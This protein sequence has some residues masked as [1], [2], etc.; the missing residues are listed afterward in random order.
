M[1][2]HINRVATDEAGDGEGQPPQ[3]AEQRTAQKESRETKPDGSGMALE[4]RFH[5]NLHDQ[6]LQHYPRPR[7]RPRLPSLAG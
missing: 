1:T 7:Y 6:R 5:V 4:E 2:L 3:A